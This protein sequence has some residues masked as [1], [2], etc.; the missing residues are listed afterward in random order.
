MQLA[1]KDIEAIVAMY[2]DELKEHSIAIGA[3]LDGEDKRLFELLKTTGV[4]ALVSGI[5]TGLLLAAEGVTDNA[6]I[7]S[8]FLED[9]RKTE[10]AKVTEG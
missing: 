3:D 7:T 1:R 2:V 5:K 6:N 8:S 4:G 10:S 9:M